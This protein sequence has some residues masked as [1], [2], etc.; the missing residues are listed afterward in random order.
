MGA[1]RQPGTADERSRERSAYRIILVT[2]IE[3]FDGEHRDDATRARL[4]ILL[5]HLLVSALGGTGIRDAEYTMR[6]TGDG[7]LVAV[8]PAVGK[9]RILGPVVDRL[10]TGL[11]RQNRHPDP[12]RRLRVRM[13]LHAGD[14][15]IAA[16]GELVGAELNFAFRLLDAQQLRALLRHASGPLVVC[17]SD[18]LYRQVVAQ[19]HEGLDPAAFEAVRLV[20]KKTRGLGWVRAPGEPGL[21][22]RS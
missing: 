16:D 21:V 8:D 20:R 17:V 15:L 11:R 2:D 9:P 1:K 22:A 13:V 3:G 10:A 18:A 7:W 5:R 4:R 14:M 19:R 6:T 12:A